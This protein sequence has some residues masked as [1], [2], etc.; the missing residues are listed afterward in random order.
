MYAH[1]YADTMLARL[2]IEEPDYFDDKGISKEEFSL[3][4]Q[5]NI[6]LPVLKFKNAMYADAT[7]ELTEKMHLQD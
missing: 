7:V 6:C 1:A 5:Q 3:H 2:T 4:L